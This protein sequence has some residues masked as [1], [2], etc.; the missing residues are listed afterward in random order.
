[1]T[2]WLDRL[3]YKKDKKASMYI[4]L[5]VQG[6]VSPIVSLDPTSSDYQ[7]VYSGGTIDFN[8]YLRDGVMQYPGS[9]RPNTTGNMIVMGHSSYLAKDIGRYKTVFQRLTVTYIDQ[10][11]RVYAKN[12]S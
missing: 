3:P 4:V 11:V 6:V 2:Y 7:T 9:S 10:E 8:T 1:L 5:P 12:A